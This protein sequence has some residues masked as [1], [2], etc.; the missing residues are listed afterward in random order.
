[1]ATDVPSCWFYELCTT[2]RL[3]T[4]LTCASQIKTCALYFLCYKINN[5]EVFRTIEHRWKRIIKRNLVTKTAPAETALCNICRCNKY[6]KIKI[7]AFPRVKSYGLVDINVLEGPVLFFYSE[8]GD[9]NSLRT[10]G[11]YLPNYAASPYTR[12]WSILIAATASD[13]NIITDFRG[14]S[15]EWCVRRRAAINSYTLFFI[16]K[17]ALI[18]RWIILEARKTPALMLQ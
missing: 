17:S 7:V 10:T 1:M 12:S 16:G 15:I 3:R 4:Y 11:T 6:I 2:G 14:T 18:I 13:Q 9:S 8:D 5:V